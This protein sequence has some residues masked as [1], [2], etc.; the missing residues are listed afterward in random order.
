MQTTENSSIPSLSDDA[1]LQAAEAHIRERYG[2]TQDVNDPALY[3]CQDANS[4]AYATI[5]RYL[6]YEPVDPEGTTYW[7]C[8]DWYG[9]IVDSGAGR[10]HDGVVDIDLLRMQA[11]DG[12]PYRPHKNEPD[13]YCLLYTSPSPRD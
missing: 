12:V 1:V 10:S 9:G 6:V 3:T 13:F 7:V 5:E 2:E 4:L 8:V 11:V